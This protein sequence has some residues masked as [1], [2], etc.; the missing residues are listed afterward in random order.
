V[1]VV[2]TDHAPHTVAEKTAALADAPSGVPGVETMLPLLLAAVRD[3]TLS[4][5]RVRDVTASNPASI[6]G[7]EQKGRIVEGADADLVLVD[8]STSR[9]IEAGALHAKCGWTPFEGRAGV[10]PELT[11]VRG[12]VAYERDP[13]TGAESFGEPIGQNVCGR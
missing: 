5:E 8:L 4:L 11:L 3:E 13:V 10:F 12:S 9:E 2:A 7:L 6:F 1:A